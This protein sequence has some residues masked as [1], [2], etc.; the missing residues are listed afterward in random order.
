MTRK[1]LADLLGL[2]PRQI[3]NLVVEGIPRRKAGRSYDYGADAVAWYFRRKLEA[4]ESAR[5]P[6]LDEARARKETAQAELAEYQLDEV[7]G[8]MIKKADSVAQVSRVYDLLRAKLLNVPGRYA[9]QLVGLRSYAEARTALEKI[10]DDILSSFAEEADEIEADD[11][12]E[13]DSRVAT[14]RGK[15]GPKAA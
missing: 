9:T 4:L 7:R 8:Q 10:V 11:T 15:R 6:S 3:D 2:K 14:G 12:P 13:R 1:E 5:P